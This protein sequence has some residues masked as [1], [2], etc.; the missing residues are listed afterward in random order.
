M[1]RIEFTDDGR[2]RESLAIGV[3]GVAS[4]V[5]IVAALLVFHL[6]PA[7]IAGPGSLGQFAAI[8]ATVSAIVVFVFGRYAVRDREHP[9]R[10]MDLVDLGVVALVHG[11]IA[12]L[13]WTLLSAIIG[14]SFAHMVVYPIP[15]LFITGAVSAVTTYLVLHAATG[16]S[17]MTLAIVLAVFLAEGLVASMLSASNP[18]W[19]RDNLSAL[20]IANDTSALTFNL[21]LIVGGIM[22]TTLT[23]YITRALPGASAGGVARLRVFLVLMG[24]LLALVGLFPVDDFFWVHTSSASGMG[25]V[26][27]VLALRVQ[28]WVPGLARGF[29]WLGR[30]FV[31]VT[32]LMG[33]LYA[34]GYYT[35][36]AVELIA[37]VMAF[38]WII[39]FI[40]NTALASVLV[41][42]IAVEAW[43]GAAAAAPADV[44]R[45][46]V[47]AV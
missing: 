26:F 8:V 27:C 33:A 6:E 9:P 19:W 16:S 24:V 29:I 31:G 7:P 5:S 38:T 15:L 43:A 20:G 10:L 12:L 14:Q 44:A 30:V 4:L 13:S 3:A 39:L 47:P 22:I 2:G 36:T 25:V 42:E 45:E 32:V 35:L 1:S 41:T 28:T 46:P 21:T 18:H 37:A 17:L 23:R 11:V 40:R 34:V